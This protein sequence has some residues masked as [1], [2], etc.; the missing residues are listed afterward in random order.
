MKS[1]RKISI[2]IFNLVLVIL[3]IATS[4][5]A[6]FTSI[7]QSKDR[8]NIILSDEYANKDINV[9]TSAYI[10]KDFNMDGVLDGAN[11][12]YTSY[13]SYMD[14]N[15]LLLNQ[16][17]NYTVNNLYAGNIITYCIR[18]VNKEPTAL[19][20][21]AS[22]LIS[23]DYV[24][25]SIMFEV[26]DV[27]AD[28]FLSTYY[29]Q[30]TN[31]SF[32]TSQDVTK[33]L[34]DSYPLSY[35]EEYP[36]IFNQKYNIYDL[37]NG[38]HF[39]KKIE[40]P[41]ASTALVFY[42]IKTLSSVEMNDY[43]ENYFYDY[44]RNFYEDNILPAQAYLDEYSSSTHPELDTLMSIENSFSINK[45]EFDQLIDWTNTG[46]VENPV[47]E[48]AEVESNYENLNTYFRNLK[49]DNHLV[50]F[51]DNI[52]Y[53]TSLDYKSLYLKELAIKNIIN[54]N[55]SE[56]GSTFVIDSISIYINYLT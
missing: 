30:D 52:S 53:L 1:T 4:S 35:K 47:Y 55:K 56:I 27:Y 14:G 2:L 37:K 54:N 22:F 18:I 41:I 6:W 36:S 9:E 23:K 12:T 40:I 46:S 21:D 7:S 29:T 34:N 17:D 19:S 13:Q 38:N 10:G 31:E 5:Y 25:K 26:Y 39:L 51:D 24:N 48:S 8:Q 45:N 43:A 42:K 16:S 28:E 20:I 3:L 15:Y 49:S 33:V 32:M 11:N 50:L 44:Y